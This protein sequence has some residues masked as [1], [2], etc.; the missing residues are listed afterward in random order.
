MTVK[1]PELVASNGPGNVKI[2]FHC[3]SNSYLAGQN[4]QQESKTRSNNKAEYVACVAGA[5]P[6][7]VSTRKKGRASVSPSIPR[8]RSLFRP[9]SVS[10]RMGVGKS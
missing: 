4:Y 8:P 6:E 3:E 1:D 5:W 7:V 2:L 9:Q 10:F